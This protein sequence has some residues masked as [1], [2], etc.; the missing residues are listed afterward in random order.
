MPP[1]NYKYIGSFEELKNC[2]DPAVICDGRSVSYLELVSE[3]KKTARVML[4]CGIRK[5]DAVMF[6]MSYSA[7]LITAYMAM[8]YAGILPVFIDRSWP[9]ERLD[10]IRKD[11]GAVLDLTDV[12]YAS[13]KEQ[14]GG[15]EE[16]LKFLSFWNLIP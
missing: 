12:V 7:D 15:C 16:S 1:F 6:S 9:Q 4:S 8:I 2:P 14:A 5:G 10:F 11:C 13:W 3:A